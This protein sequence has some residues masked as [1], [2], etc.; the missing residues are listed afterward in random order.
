MD[1][2]RWYRSYLTIAAPLLVAGFLASAAANRL[3]FAAW[4][5]ASALAYGL[6][7]RWALPRRRRAPARLALIASLTT[8]GW[9]VLRHGEALALGVAAL[10]P[11]SEGAS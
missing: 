11:A 10:L 5:L 2:N 7:L 4:G 9:L 8:L 6:A 3:A 1:A